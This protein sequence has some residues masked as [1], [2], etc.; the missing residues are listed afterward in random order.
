MTDEVDRFDHWFE[1]VIVPS[2]KRQRGVRLLHQLVERF[3]RR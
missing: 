3:A 2:M 1:T